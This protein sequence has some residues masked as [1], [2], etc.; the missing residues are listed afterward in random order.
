MNH[1][2]VTYDLEGNE[3]KE[4]DT[5]YLTECSDKYLNN[6]FEKEFILKSEK[7]N[8]QWYCLEDEDVLLSGTYDSP[9][10]KLDHAYLK[11][12]IFRCS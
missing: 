6:D 3:N 11:Y 9:I 4:T 8:V 2:K 10:K 12:E 5:H 7:R 1:Y